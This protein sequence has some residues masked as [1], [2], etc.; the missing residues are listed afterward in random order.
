M[1]GDFRSIMHLSYRDYRTIPE[2]LRGTGRDQIDEIYLKENL[3][4]TLP[5]WFFV[6]MCHLRF[7]Y[8]A[9]NMIETLPNQIGRLECLE[10]LDLS[11]NSLHR[12]PNSIGRL[13]R[14]TKLMLN[15]NHIHQ[16]PSEIGHLQRLEE[17]HVRKNRLT[18]IPVQLSQCVSL[19]ELQMDDNPGLVSIPTR[20]C[21]LPVLTYVSAERCNLFQ[22]P[23]TINT[24]TLCFVL[25]FNSNQSLTHCP[26]ALERFA[27][28]DYDAMED[29]MKRIKNPSCYRQ[30][31]CK[32]VPYLLNFP[33]ELGK[34]R[35]RHS[36]GTVPHSLFETALRASSRYRLLRWDH[37]ERY[38]LPQCLM[39]RLISGAVGCCSSVPCGKEIFSEA[40]LA[41]VK[42]KEYA[43][44]F[45]LSVLFCSHLCADRWFQYNCDAYEELDWDIPN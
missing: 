38:G 11:D 24:T 31:H 23:F 21:N 33:S 26:L 32:V 14:L 1:E 41:L 20:V 6:E 37:T 19:E 34:L 18:N 8:L 28:P 30:I 44:N 39:N 12:L 35:N 42:R 27:Q 29:K 25:L 9:G 13:K 5:D 3:I 4:H 43:R 17:L 2:E 22:L 7:L 36:S 15:G 10:T 40:V 16:L 45:V